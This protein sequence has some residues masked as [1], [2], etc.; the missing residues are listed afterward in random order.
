M[1]TVKSYNAVGGN[2]LTWVSFYLLMGSRCFGGI[3]DSQLRAVLLPTAQIV[4]SQ[5]AFG[6]ELGH[7][8]R[9]HVMEDVSHTDIVWSLLF[10]ATSYN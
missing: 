8:L 6:I 10:T 2:F 5:G 3:D 1:E 4:S 7:R 9:R